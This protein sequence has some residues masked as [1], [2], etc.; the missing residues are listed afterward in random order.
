MK[1]EMAIIDHLQA[2][3]MELGRGARQQ[4]VKTDMGDFYIDLVFYN[5]ILKSYLI[6]GL[7]ITQLTHQDVGQVD[8]YIRMYDE[9]KKEVGNNP[10]IGLLLCAD[11][12][13]DL[14]CYSILNES[15]QPFAAKYLTYLPSE[16]DLSR[17][18]RKQKEFFER[19][20]GKLN[21]G[22]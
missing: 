10:T 12:S 18:I 1:L 3:I 5:I 17:E 21:L 8:M 11:T 9:L 6:I 19:Q 16:E 20:Q 14:A 2:F 22:Q 15:K 13:N 7:K 4:H